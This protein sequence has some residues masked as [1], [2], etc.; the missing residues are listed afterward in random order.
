MF[1]NP[2]MKQAQLIQWALRNRPLDRPPGQ[3]YP[4]SNFGFC[5]LGRVIEKV[6]HSGYGWAAFTNTRRQDSAMHG[7][8]DKLIWTMVGQVKT[9]HA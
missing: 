8:L 1:M 3:S 5:V 9:W 6:T 2:G 7:D 4:Y